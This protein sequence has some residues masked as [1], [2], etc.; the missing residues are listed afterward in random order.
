MSWFAAFQWV[1]DLYL[2]ASGVAL[3]LPR[4]T[5]LAEEFRPPKSCDAGAV[6]QPVLHAR[7]RPV[8]WTDPIRIQWGSSDICLGSSEPYNKAQ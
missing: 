2:H 1:A 7:Q 5:D 4:V 8:A 3:D 6:T